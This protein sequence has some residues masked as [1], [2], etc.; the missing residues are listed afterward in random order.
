MAASRWGKKLALFSFLLLVTDN[1]YL[2]NLLGA[3]FEERNCFTLLSTKSYVLLSVYETS[4]I[5]SIKCFFLILKHVS[6]RMYKML[7]TT[8]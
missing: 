2:C 8:N 6:F 5:Q 7:N 4:E 3:K 1:Y